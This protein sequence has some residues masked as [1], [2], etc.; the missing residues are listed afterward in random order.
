MKVFQHKSFNT[1]STLS[2]FWILP[3]FY[4][5]VVH[6]Q[7]FSFLSVLRCKLF[8]LEYTQSDSKNILR[9]GATLILY[10][11]S[12]NFIYFTA[13]SMCSIPYCWGQKLQCAKGTIKMT[14]WSFPTCECALLLQNIFF[15][16][17]QKHIW[18]LS[19]FPFTP[20]LFLLVASLS[21]CLVFLCL[22]YFFN[23]LFITKNWL[24]LM[25]LLFCTAVCVYIFLFY[26]ATH[27]PFMGSLPI[28]SESY[29]S[30]DMDEL[31]TDREVRNSHTVKHLSGSV[32]LLSFKSRH[33]DTH[34]HT[35]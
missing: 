31:E 3:C 34:T 11:A 35:Q 14:F 9:S 24:F 4:W 2:H 18:S 22:P 28:V 13:S 12:P 25:W 27:A 33:A 19:F 23:L 7:A 21:C 10:Y 32:P 15:F 30:W 8:S 17:C 1:A 16:K 6:Q 29:N 26:C 5:V 20:F